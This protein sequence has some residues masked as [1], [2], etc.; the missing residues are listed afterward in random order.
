MIRRSISFDVPSPVKFQLY[1]SH[2]RSILEYCSPIWSPANVKDILL[3]ERVQ[4]HATKY[5]LNNY[6]DFSYAERCIKLSI[7]PLCFRREII[8]LL[9]FLKYLNSYVDCN[10]SSYFE[11]VGSLHKLRSSSN[12]TLLKLPRVKTTALQ[13]SYFYRLVRLWNSLSRDIREASSVFSFKKYINNLYF[14]RLANFNINERC[15]WS[16]A[17]TCGFC[18]P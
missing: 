13:S 16:L 14:S 1:V 12:G 8:D 7:L 18:R 9:L 11:L 10:F 15:T 17:C 6:S 2:I 4:R 3:L 5:I